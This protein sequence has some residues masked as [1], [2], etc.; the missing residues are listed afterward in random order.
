ME[1]A[2]VLHRAHVLFYEHRFSQKITV[3]DKKGAADVLCS[4]EAVAEHLYHMGDGLIP[5]PASD[6]SILI[7]NL[8]GQRQ[9]KELCGISRQYVNST[10]EVSMDKRRLGGAF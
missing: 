2:W 3:Q 4:V 7:M 8:D 10:P 1:Q 5:E 6:G 9:T